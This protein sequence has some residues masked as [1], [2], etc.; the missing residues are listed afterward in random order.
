MFVYNSSK[1]AVTQLTK[2]LAMDLAHHSIRVNAI[3][4]GAIWTPASYNHMKYLNLSEEEGK[5]VRS[6]NP[7]FD[8]IP[9]MF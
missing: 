1:G 9:M 2:C 7:L 5:K 6:R 3:C 8:S 4:P